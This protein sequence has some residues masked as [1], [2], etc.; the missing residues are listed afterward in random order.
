MDVRLET[1]QQ[2]ANKAEFLLAAA[3]NVVG[4]GNVWR[5]PYLCYK[6][7][8]GVFL[9]PY[10]FFALLCGLPVYL[11]E[12]VMGQ[13]T[14]EGSATCWTKLCPLA[15]GTGYFIIVVQLYSRAYS[16]VLAWALLYLIYSFRDPLPWATCSNPW[17]T[18]RCVDLTS[19]NLT[20]AHG[21]NLSANWTLGNNKSSVSEFWERGVLSMSGGIEELGAVKWELLLCLFACWTCCYFCVWKGVHSAGKVVYFTAVFPYVMLAVLLVR[22]LTLPGAWQGVV[23]YLYPEVSHLAEL[24]VWMEACAQVMFSYGLASG[25]IITMG[26]YNRASNNCYRD[27]LWL[28]LINSCT[29]FIAG[30]AVFSALGFMAQKQ[31]VPIDMVVDSGPG[32]AF[33]AFPQAVAMMP[34]PQ[35]WAS[36]FFIM[37]L[38]LGVD[39]VFTGLETLTASAIDLFPRQMRRPWRREVFLL[40]FCSLSFLL[41]I[42][43]TT[44]GG[45]YIFELIDY[46]GANGAC[47]LFGCVVQCVAVGWAFGAGRM[48]DEVAAMTGERPWAL[49]TLCW[50][51][52][53]PLICTVSFVGS[54]LDYQPLTS[55]GGHR[56]PD[57]AYGLG[58][59]MVFSSVGLVPVWAVGRLCVTEGT[60]RQRLSL[61][62][63]PVNDP[64]NVRKNSAAETAVDPDPVWTPRT[65]LDSLQAPRAPDDLL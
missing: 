58:S 7:G 39:T 44:Q 34:L 29:S 32:L 33:I 54:F 42:P 55:K 21:G 36:C 28:C 18:D 1:R 26:S 49:F 63:R 38:L 62:W 25:S 60:L 20:E 59:V 16:I 2:W 15:Q 11:L 51:Y 6:N 31:G 45:V 47:I 13:F 3:G 19:V 41:Q 35:L 50:R 8:G 37:L 5:F 9:L 64:V 53:T 65:D 57:W 14:Q 40:L 22:G 48:C 17:N 12:T 52:L 27:C 4:L 56:Y 61:L 24:R 30:F 43:L 10:C 46:Y 23:Y